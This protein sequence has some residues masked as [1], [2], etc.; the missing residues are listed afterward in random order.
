MP[1]RP[2]KTRAVT[3]TY[4]LTSAS[5]RDETVS[6]GIA[7]VAGTVAE[8]AKTPLPLFGSDGPHVADV[9]DVLT[10]TGWFEVTMTGILLTSEGF[11]TT[12][13]TDLNETHASVQLMLVSSSTTEPAR[14]TTVTTAKRSWSPQSPYAWP[15]VVY[16]AFN[17]LYAETLRQTTQ[18]DAMQATQNASQLFSAFYGKARM[19]LCD[20]NITGRLLIVQ[21]NTAT[22]PVTEAVTQ[23]NIANDTV[24]HVYQTSGQ[25]EVAET[26]RSS[27]WPD[28]IL[29]VWR[30]DG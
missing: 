12:N 13:M 26:R 9:S 25:I 28:C 17:S 4:I 22:G 30:G 29:V 16:D 5:D 15:A 11:I 14:V 10:T 1:F 24:Q 3:K 21:H 8:I 2:H 23:N 18:T 7:L 27:W 6:Y 19:R 20:S